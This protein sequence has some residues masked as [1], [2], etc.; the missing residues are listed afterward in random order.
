MGGG[1]AFGRWS[2]VGLEGRC[3]RAEKCQ[4]VDLIECHVTNW[5]SPG[6]SLTSMH[7]RVCSGNYVL[8]STV[9]GGIPFL[10][11][12]SVPSESFVFVQCATTRVSRS[13][14]LCWTN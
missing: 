4:W 5:A 11:C 1:L 13:T 9:S 14:N 2:R 6:P 10:V 7:A 8:G 3:R 12:T